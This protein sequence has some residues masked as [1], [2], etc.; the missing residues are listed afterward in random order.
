MKLIPSNIIFATLCTLW[1][2][3]FP[4]TARAEDCLNLEVNYAF[5]GA[6]SDDRNILLECLNGI[7][8]DCKL[9]EFFQGSLAAA[10]LRL[11]G[12]SS[13]IDWA[14]DYL[15]KIQKPKDLFMLYGGGND[16]LGPYPDWTGVTPP[17]FGENLPDD[18][19]AEYERFLA[20]TAV[21]NFAQALER[22]YSDLGAKY[23][24]VPNFIDPCSVPVCEQLGRD[25]GP[26]FLR[27]IQVYASIWVDQANSGLA[28]VVAKFTKDH[29]DATIVSVDVNSALTSLL[30][31][32]VFIND[33]TSCEDAA[34]SGTLRGPDSNG[35][36]DC[37]TY[38]FADSKHPTSLLWEH[39]VQLAFLPA[40]EEQ[41]PKGVSKNFQRLISFG[42]SYSDKGSAKDTLDR[43]IEG[44]AAA[45][46]VP[47]LSGSTYANELNLVELLEDALDL[48]RSTP[49]IQPSTNDPKEPVSCP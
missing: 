16:H 35:F 21:T 17:A 41:V 7:F 29:P 4:S 44:L 8:F 2:F 12:I 22:V 31:S 11:P 48:H 3:S 25:Y 27:G 49:F 6:M 13:Q 23:I 1:S 43:S 32:G 45:Q 19:P 46:R 37:G 20:R 14:K 42:D 34:L 47:P 39:I 28:Q 18:F 36:W 24:V 30:D 5:G 40:I 33:G 9:V 10:G 38:A 15:G 26:L